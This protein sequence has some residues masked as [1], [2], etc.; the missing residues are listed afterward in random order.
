MAEIVDNSRATADMNIVSAESYTSSQGG[1]VT[2][3]TKTSTML[4]TWE[5]G[6]FQREDRWGGQQGNLGSQ[7][8]ASSVGNSARAV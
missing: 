2:I 7:G 8:N 1:S 5:M 3:S 4:Q 6:H